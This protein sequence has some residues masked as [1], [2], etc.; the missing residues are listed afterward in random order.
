[1]SIRFENLTLCTSCLVSHHSFA[2]CLTSRILH[3]FW[4]AISWC[5]HN[6]P[7]LLCICIENF[8]L[9][10]FCENYFFQLT[11]FSRYVLTFVT[12]LFQ[13]IVNKLENNLFN[14]RSP[15]KWHDNWQKN[16][17]MKCFFDEIE[18]WLCFEFADQIQNRANFW[19]LQ[20]IIH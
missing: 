5:G 17:V 12:F 13:F 7:K 9:L 16:V 2:M 3:P 19:G 10:Q 8:M 11:F 14:H 15:K 1:M 18:Y 4:W 20:N 6:F